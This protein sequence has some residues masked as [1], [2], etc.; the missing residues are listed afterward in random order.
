MS[1]APNTV[2]RRCCSQDA[3]K[4]CTLIIGLNILGQESPGSGTRSVCTCF[5]TGCTWCCFVL[6]IRA[7]FET[8][9]FPVA[10]QRARELPSA[11]STK[12]PIQFGGNRRDWRGRSWEVC[13]RQGWSSS[14]LPH[15]Q[16]PSP[17]DAPGPHA[18]ARQPVWQE[19]Q[20]AHHT[21]QR[22]P[23][24]GGGRRPCTVES[25]A[26][27]KAPWVSETGVLP[28]SARCADS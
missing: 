25:E 23:A 6:N 26:G 19:E 18:D 10:G 16:E 27:R 13:G 12:G 5:R 8:L 15:G 20:T 17:R 28:E 4:C 24:S 1:H 2:P 14:R 22:D 3:G 9:C 7:K 21:Q 11:T